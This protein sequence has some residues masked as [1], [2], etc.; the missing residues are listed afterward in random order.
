VIK[1]TIPGLY[2][3]QWPQWLVI[4]GGSILRLFRLDAQ[5]LWFDEASRLAQAS[6]D[7]GSI[8]Q[9]VAQDTQPPLYHLTQHF[10]LS[11]GENDYLVRFLP[12][13]MGILLIAVVYRLGYDIFDRKT[14]L[15]AAFL[16]AIMPYQV[17]HSQQ[18]NLYALLVVLSGL[19]TL[20]FWR[21][22]Q[23]N[24]WRDWLLFGLWTLLGLYTQ[25]LSTFVTITLHLFL[26][27]FSKRHPNR[28]GRLLT[29]DILVGLAFLPQTTKLLN[30]I[31]TISNN[32]WLSKPSLLAPFATLYLFMASYSLPARLAA[33]A[34]FVTLAILAFGIL[35]LSFGVKKRIER[36]EALLFLVLL[37]FVP[38]LL[39]LVI[40]QIKPIFLERSL[41]TVTPAYAVLL[42]R[43]LRSS[44]WQSPLPYLY[45][46]VIGIMSISLFHYYF[47]PAF[48]KPPYREATHY[49]SERF[50]AGDI[51][52]HTGNGSYLPFLFYNPPSPHYLLVGDPAPHHPPE[53]FRMKGGREVSFN[54]FEGY[55]RLWLVV[56][57]DH[58]VDYQRATVNHFDT[59]YPLLSETTIGGIIIRVYDIQSLWPENLY[60]GDP[61]WVAR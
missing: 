42:G 32:F 57:L 48:A 2:R 37:T 31:D 12:A 56:A 5:S 33:V 24:R 23:T 22:V 30:G 34:I 11:L 14:A 51:V 40:S 59:L 3:S 25:Y 9:N 7:L 35:E 52:V 36:G 53:V 17:Y 54:D 26:L 44:R 4:L 58:S 55:E 1:P 49:I 39:A 19:Q 28:W 27:I 50:Q 47:N 15:I 21:S 45:G 6:A 60:P 20:F 13:I 18:A 8:L 10:W 61:N 41:I 38:I 29:V 46:L 16:I 43:A